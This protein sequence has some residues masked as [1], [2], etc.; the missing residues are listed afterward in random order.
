MVVS[1]DE[2]NLLANRD[3]F[4]PDVGY[5]KY[6]LMVVRRQGRFP[7]LTIFPVIGFLRSQVLTEDVNKT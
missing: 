4:L 1:D 3:V 2:L 7:I 6:L 5:P